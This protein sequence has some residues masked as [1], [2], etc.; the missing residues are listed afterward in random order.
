MV[1]RSMRRC[2][3]CAPDTR[4]SSCSTGP[5]MSGFGSVV[6]RRGCA[7]GTR[8]LIARRTTKTGRQASRDNTNN[9][10]NCVISGGE[11]G[12]FDKRCS[13]PWPRC[14]CERG[15]NTSSPSC[16]GRVRSSSSV[17]RAGAAP[18]VTQRTPRNRG[19]LLRFAPCN[20]VDNYPRQLLG[21]DLPE[22]LQV[23]ASRACGV[24][25]GLM[26]GLFFLMAVFLGS[27]AANCRDDPISLQAMGFAQLALG[28]ALLMVG[29]TVTC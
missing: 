19:R 7:P 23:G 22:D 20:Y 5:S 28:C 21:S 25:W 27:H 8:F 14:V 24:F 17:S 9:R 6:I 16:S 29:R 2:H 4:T 18:T 26:P 1:P 13:I 12:W 10:E 15:L 3:A 11:R